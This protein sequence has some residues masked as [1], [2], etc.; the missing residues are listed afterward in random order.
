MSAPLKRDAAVVFVPLP[1][2]LARVAGMIV[3]FGA[4]TPPG[5]EFQNIRGSVFA[6]LDGNV[7]GAIK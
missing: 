7:A 6:Q 3:T 1:V 4:Y 2:F 5:S